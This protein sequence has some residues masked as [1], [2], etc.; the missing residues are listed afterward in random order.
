MSQLRRL[1][2]AAALACVTF[3]GSASP[4]FATQSDTANQWGRHIAR[5][6]VPVANVRS[7]PS[8][9]C[10]IV[11]KVY[12]STRVYVYSRRGGWTNIGYNRWIAS[13]LITR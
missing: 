6:V 13:Y 5:V 3:A 11:F 9:S 10:R 1:F 8:T 12:R 7:C 2:A 4:A